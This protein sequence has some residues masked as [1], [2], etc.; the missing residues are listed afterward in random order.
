VS[1]EERTARSRPAARVRRGP[2]TALETFSRG[3]T[4][5]GRAFLTGG[6]V[7]TACATALD[8]QP[9]LRVAILLVALP[10]A[11]SAVTAT[12]RYRIAC[13]RTLD[14]PRVPVGTPARVQLRLENAARLPSAPLL[15]EDRV[16]YTLGSRP[17]FVLRR[18]EPGG[19]RTV[20]YRVRSD[21]RGRYLLGPL[22]LRTADP[23]GLFE[24]TRAFTTQ[25]TLTVAPRVDP[26]PSTTLGTLWAGNGDGHA[27][28]AAAAGE[29]DVGVREYHY[30][31]ELRRIHWRATAHHG[32][33]MVR[34]EEQTWHSRCTVVLDTRTSSHRGSGPA[35]SL[36]WAISAG[37]ST[38]VHLL[39]AG[40]T[41]R[42]AT[43]AGVVPLHVETEDAVLDSLAVLRP[44]H[45]S[46][47]PLGET[48][49]DD[50]TDSLLIA[51]LGALGGRDVAE[52]AR[53]RPSSGTAVAFLLDTESWLAPTA[54]RREP[55]QAATLLEASGW[56]VLLAQS[57][58]RFPDLWRLAA[59]R[60]NAVTAA[61]AAPR[62]EFP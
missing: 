53:A 19:S 30:G 6:L 27:A 60:T 43:T 55:D 34:R 3:L 14:P 35:S 37:A 5:R 57:T 29:D 28:H 4:T 31:D 59:R 33:M 16:P 1:T 56:R 32:E 47:L 7:G 38:A 62:Q 20:A 51:F 18:I 17:R 49:T 8:Y 61:E 21:N 58:D 9:L 15:V 54:G 24:L 25:H 26:L 40:Y 11:A 52:L 13:R 45:S 39:R 10:V 12:S 46:A 36:E 44:T 22:T 23:L 48:S 42:L 50:T 2:R 41:V